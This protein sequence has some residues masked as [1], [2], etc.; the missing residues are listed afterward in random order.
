[1][2]AASVIGVVLAG[3]LS[4]STNWAQDTPSVDAL[5][6]RVQADP[7]SG[8]DWYALGR[9]L[10]DRAEYVSAL[11]AFERAIEL[12]FQAEG[13][14]LRSAQI[15]AA[16]G[17]TEDALRRLERAAE[18]GP[19]VISLLPQIGG[20]PELAGDPRFQKIVEDAER[21]RHPCATRS[22]SRQF[23]FWLGEWTVSGPQ[24]Q[25]VGE[26]VI[27]S[28]LEGCVVRESWTSAYGDRGTSVNTWDPATALWHQ[29][30]T[31][32]D[33]TVTHYE[34]GW[35]GGQMRF[36]A[37][38]FGDADGKTGH[39]RMTFTP[40]PD[41]SVRQLIEVSSDGTTWQVGFDGLYRAKA[42][43]GASPVE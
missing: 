9:A 19:L 13:A 27:T 30:W 43:S 2:R 1:M 40:N 29:I 37:T 34:G 36:V 35:R 7:D 31:S 10:Q 32:E 14:W 21:A 16:R 38:G 3:L 28:D 6:A 42:P 41:G 25:V 22:E 20:I 18:V 5:R 15:V 12:D 8:A 39:R 17:D 26:N 23:D 24:G 33:G 11:E 4:L